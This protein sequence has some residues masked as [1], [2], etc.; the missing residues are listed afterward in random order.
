VGLCFLFDGLCF[1]LVDF[2]FYL[3]GFRF[4]C[5]LIDLQ[6]IDRIIL[7]IAQNKSYA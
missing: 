1:L 5:I 4:C 3:V 7:Y 6:M 2:V